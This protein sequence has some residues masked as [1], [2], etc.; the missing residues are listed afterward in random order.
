MSVLS[1]WQGV[2]SDVVSDVV[3]DIPESYMG[4]IG[5][6]FFIYLFVSSVLY[7]W[8]FSKLLAKREFVKLASVGETGS[9]GVYGFVRVLFYALEFIVIL[10][11]LV[12]LWFYFFASFLLFIPG[13]SVELTFLL[14]FVLVIC[15]RIVCCF[16]EMV[17]LYFTRGVGLIIFLIFFVSYF[18]IDFSEVSGMVFYL[19]GNFGVI[20]FY[21]ILVVLIEACLRIVFH[22]GFFSF[23]KS[24]F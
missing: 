7:I 13:I 21:F 2:I 19:I 5:I 16:D 10:P 9:S 1:Y 3:A 18:F 20:L 4:V 22:L 11:I 14:T 17:A 15:A 24:R 23:L 8:I 12:L 6:G